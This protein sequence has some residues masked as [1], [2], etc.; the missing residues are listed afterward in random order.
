MQTQFIGLLSKLGRKMSGKEILDLKDSRNKLPIFVRTL[1]F[2]SLL[3]IIFSK[4]N[5]NNYVLY[6]DYRVL[7]AIFI[8]FM[9]VNNTNQR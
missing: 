8:L 7:A 4:F 9:I 5:I 3:F 6:L 1:S 2:I